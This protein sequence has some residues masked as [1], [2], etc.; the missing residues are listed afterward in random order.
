MKFWSVTLLFL[1]A[2]VGVDRVLGVIPTACLRPDPDNT[3]VYQLDLIT[4][5]GYCKTFKCEIPQNQRTAYKSWVIGYL[6]R[7]KQTGAQ[8]YS[9][10]FSQSSH[11]DIYSQ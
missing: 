1:I 2:F 7:N 3:D 4:L 5:G 10:L 11:F 9:Y 6:L 8:K